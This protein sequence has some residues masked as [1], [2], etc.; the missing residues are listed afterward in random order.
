MG[1]R[2]YNTMVELHAIFNDTSA[3]VKDVAYLQVAT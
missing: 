1:K 2:I 3:S